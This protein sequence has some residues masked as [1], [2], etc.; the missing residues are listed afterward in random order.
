MQESIWADGCP[1][2]VDEKMKINIQELMLMGIDFFVKKYAI[3]NGFKI[4]QTN[5]KLG[6]L[7]NVII[8]KDNVVYGVAIVPFIF[9]KYGMLTDGARISMVK[10]LKEQN[11]IPLFAPIGFMSTDKERA[12][13]EMAL[14]GD[15]F[16]IMFRGFIELTDE[17][18]QNLAGDLRLFKMLY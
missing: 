10:T 6:L 7:P 8:K 14:K 5:G 16:N 3:P 2:N 17:E 1:Q 4:E 12:K 9:P 11:V 18:H 15:T 13:A